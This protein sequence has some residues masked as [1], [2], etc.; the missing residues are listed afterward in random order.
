MKI[1]IFTHVMPEKYK[2]RIY[3]YADRF[4]TEKA[5]QDKRPTLTDNDARLRKLDGHPDL[6]QILSTT[7]PPVEEIVTDPKRPRSWPVCATTRCRNWWRRPPALHRSH[8]EC[9]SEQHRYSREGGRAGHKGAGFQRDSASHPS[10]R[11]TP[12]HRRDAAPVRA[13][14][15]ARS[16][17]LAPSHAQFEPAGLDLR[18]RSPTINCFPYT[19]GL[20]TLLLRWCACLCRY[21]REV[22]HHKDHH[23]PLGGHGPVLF[24]QSRCPLEQRTSAPRC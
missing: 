22:P 17:H 24:R 2:Q 13:H 7:M 1:D 5:V 14:G 10:E 6:V 11:Q 9:A 15:E 8:R 4:A 16:A 3:R 23:P 20:M 12:E 19:G 21:L 18:G